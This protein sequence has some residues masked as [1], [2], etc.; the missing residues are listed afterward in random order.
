VQAAHLVAMADAD[1]EVFQLQHLV[2]HDVHHAAMIR[3]Q[4]A[5]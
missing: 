3:L 1:L 2:I 5:L 4:I